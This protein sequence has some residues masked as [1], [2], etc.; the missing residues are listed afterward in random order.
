MLSVGGEAASTLVAARVKVLMTGTINFMVIVDRKRD[1]G[2]GQ[3]IR[4]HYSSSQRRNRK[5]ATI[6]KLKK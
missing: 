5:Q 1:N 6:L 3:K 4:P 2:I